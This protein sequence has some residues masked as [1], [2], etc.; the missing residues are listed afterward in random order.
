M[1]HIAGFNSLRFFAFLSIFL[2]HTTSGFTAGKYGVD[3]FFVLSS[4]LLTYLAF[5]EMEQTGRFSRWNFFMRR[6]FRIF[7][8]YY[9]LI[10]FSFFVL[11]VLAAEAG[12]NIHLPENKWLY[13]FFLSNYET[14][15]CIFALKFFWSIAVEEQF[16]LLFLLLSLF[17]T[18]SITALVG[19]LLLAYFLFMLYAA[20]N[21]INT[22]AHTAAHLPNFTA[23]I[24]AGYFFWKKKENVLF[25][26]IAITVAALLCVLSQENTLF[27]LSLSVLFASL[28]L[29]TARYANLISGNPAFRF[30]EKM[31]TYTYGLYVYSGFIITLTAE[32]QWTDNKLIHWLYTFSL[33]ALTAVLSYHLYESRFLK[34]KSYFRATASNTAA[35]KSEK[36]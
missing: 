35:V 11:P 32:F 8:L 20:H 22:Y 5:K 29:L 25:T 17:F 27:T 28:I 4:F 36:G 9:L 13:W 21:S 6:V 26:V 14:T 18:R 12:R 33:L 7:P 24:L 10:L 1:F 19:T 34:L 23:G 3:F 16:Y 15:D 30:T 31:G 2:F